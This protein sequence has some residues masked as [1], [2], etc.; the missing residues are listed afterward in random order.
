MMTL[1]I[2][3]RTSASLHWTAL[4]DTSDSGHLIRGIVY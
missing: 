2:E 1:E 4:D 3:H